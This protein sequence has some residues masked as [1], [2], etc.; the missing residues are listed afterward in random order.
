MV[1]IN[2]LRNKNKAEDEDKENG[3]RNHVAIQFISDGYQ[4]HKLGNNPSKRL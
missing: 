4:S 3:L 1:S 2:Q